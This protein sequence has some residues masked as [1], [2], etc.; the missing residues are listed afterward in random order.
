MNQTKEAIRFGPHL[1]YLEME[2][3]G[4]QEHEDLTEIV[5]RYFDELKA[6]N[7]QL[8]HSMARILTEIEIEAASW[9]EKANVLRQK[10]EEVLNRAEALSLSLQGC[11]C[12]DCVWNQNDGCFRQDQRG[13]ATECSDYK[14]IDEFLF[15]TEQ[16]PYEY[17]KSD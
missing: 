7:G 16:G 4:M 10:A 8:N 17:L 1:R 12:A 13:T 3:N 6:N 9:I 14:D 2:V 5:E 11:V 15:D